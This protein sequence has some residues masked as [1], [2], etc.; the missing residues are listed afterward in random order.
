MSG[1]LAKISGIFV[2]QH[3]R[4]RVD[5]KLKNIYIYKERKKPEKLVQIISMYQNKNGIVN[6]SILK[7]I[8][9]VISLVQDLNNKGE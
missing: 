9:V 2:Y 7:I 6:P 5:Q 4:P 3:N 1:Q 8:I